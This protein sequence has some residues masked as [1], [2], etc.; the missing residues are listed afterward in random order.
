MPGIFFALAT[1]WNES[2]HRRVGKFLAHAF[3]QSKQYDDAVFS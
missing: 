3:N 1:Q 2:L